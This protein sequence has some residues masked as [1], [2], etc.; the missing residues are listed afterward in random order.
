MRRERSQSSKL[1]TLCSLAVRAMASPI[2]GAIEMMR[3]FLA[4]L[5]ASVAMIESVITSSFSFD[6]AMRSAAPS[7]STP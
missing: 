7:E 2:R 4:A 1:E 6:A 3:M 5:A